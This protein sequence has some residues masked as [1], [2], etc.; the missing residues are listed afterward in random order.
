MKQLNERVESDA[1]KTSVSPAPLDSGKYMLIKPLK[2]LLLC[3][4]VSLPLQAEAKSL[5][6]SEV[7]DLLLNGFVVSTDA[8][9]SQVKKQLG[10]PV[11]IKAVQVSNPYSEIKDEVTRYIYQGLEIT[12]YE[13]KNPQIRWK[14]IVEISVSSNTYKLK[15]GLTVGMT[16]TEFESKFKGR[17]CTNWRTGDL[18]YYSYSMPDSVHDQINIAVKNKIVQKI[19]WSNWP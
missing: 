19:I 12:F 7:N 11:S 3:L 1:Q 8:D 14:N 16:L 2:L 10:P 4:A 18:E 5:N 17:S 13:C 9:E 6:D 15:Y